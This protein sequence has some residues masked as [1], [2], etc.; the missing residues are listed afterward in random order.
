MEEIVTWFGRA[1]CHQLPER[2][3]TAGGHL[4]PVCARDT[5]IYIGLFSSLFYLM[6]TK[7]Y[8]SNAIPDV[9]TSLLLFLLLFPLMIDGFGS[10][11]G[12]FESNNLR[13]IITGLLFGL[14][15]PFFLV[16]L[17][18]SSYLNRT[19]VPI[20]RSFVQVLI[21]LLLSFVFAGSVY[22]SL[23]PHFFLSVFLIAMILVWFSMILANLFWRIEKWRV[24]AVLS[25]LSS[26]IFI[27]ILSIIHGAIGS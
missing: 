15:L 17:L 20:I 2:S 12:L 23:V 22:L 18:H 19:N 3:L 26:T 9:K 14:P 7:K 10:Y 8:K 21:P 1:I 25:V 5:G 24:K 6:I 11:L 16:P 13:R 27:S 4:L